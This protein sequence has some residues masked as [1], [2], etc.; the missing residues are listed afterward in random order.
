MPGRVI[1]PDPEPPSEGQES[2]QTGTKA[3]TE[4][5]PN[6]L[7]SDI[8]NENKMPEQ[9]AKIWLEFL[10]SQKVIPRNMT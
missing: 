7:W 3:F 2:T 8:N 9:K 4:P 5:P 6:N 10:Y 1:S